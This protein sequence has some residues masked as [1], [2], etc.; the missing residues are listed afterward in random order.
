MADP[1]PIV[2]DTDIGADPDDAL[3]L[4]LALAS[5]EV[6]LRG[7]TI[8]SGD[9]ELRARMAARLLG[10]A[11]RADIPVVRGLSRSLDPKG[12]STML[13]IEG[14]GLLDVDYWGPEAT[15]S[16]DDAPSW[17]VETSKLAPFHLV[18]IGP[19]SNVAAAV[20]LD[21][22]FADRLLG[23]TIMGGLL[24]ERA[25]PPAWRR[26]AGE[27][28][29]AASWPDYNT[30]CD[31]AAALVCARAGVPTTWVPIEVTLHAPLRR[32]GRD[33]LPADSPLG[34]ALGRMVDVWAKEWFRPTLPAGD[35]SRIPDAVAFLHDPLALAALFPGDWLTLRPIPMSYGVEDGRFRLRGAA[36]SGEPPARVAAA[37]DGAGFEA[38]CVERIA[39][40]IAT[41]GSPDQLV[42]EESYGL[43]PPTKT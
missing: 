26:A 40:Y 1:I 24:D 13:G 8:V 15:I 33:R 4:V 11:G 19:L 25:L 21:P 5:P 18:A 17:L 31:P 39:H 37:V 42:I 35:R 36:A 34:A 43:H 3:A 12:A 6:D 14:R 7:V 10:M 16:S 9:V 38:F 29:S 22:S 2:I 30:T 28:P 41:A 32:A 23:L 20:Q 27:S